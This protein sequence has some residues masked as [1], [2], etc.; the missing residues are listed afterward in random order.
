MKLQ[1]LSAVSKL[2]QY[3]GDRHVGDFWNSQKK[4]WDSLACWVWHYRYP[5][6][7]NVEYTLTLDRRL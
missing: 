6:R 3:V 5:V 2:A 1:A 4:S 7:L